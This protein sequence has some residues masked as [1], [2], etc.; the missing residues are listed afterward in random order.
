MRAVLERALVAVAGA[1]ASTRAAPAP[2]AGTYQVGLF[3]DMP[4]GPR[5]TARYPA[6]IADMDKV[7]LTF[8]I[9]DGDI[10]NG[11]E[12]CCAESTAPQ[13]LPGSRM[14][15]SRPCSPSTS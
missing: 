4:D 6:L 8:S 10:K 11:S 14:C 9:F 13:P 12:P 15:R 2:A 3:G 5:G 1:A 7:D